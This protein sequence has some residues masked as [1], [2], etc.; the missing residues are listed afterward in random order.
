[1]NRTPYVLLLSMAVFQMTGFAHET[2]E[3]PQRECVVLLHGLSRTA[4]SMK[5]LEWDLARH[6]YEVINVSY[7]SRRFTVEQ[8]ADEYLHPAIAGKTSDPAKKIHFVTHSMGG[9]I[10]RQYLSNHTIENLGCVVMLAPPNQGSE[11]VDQLKRV[12]IGRWILGPGGCQLD[13][14]PNG[15]PK[16]LG[17][18]GFDL[19][20]IAG[21][22]SFN[23]LFSR[24]LPGLDDGKVSVES[25]RV[26]GMKDFLVV[27]NSHTWMPWRSK[28]ISHVLD[29]LQFGGF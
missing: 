19:G 8:L 10:L 14:C 5:R 13:S 17:P 25:T 18:A 12:M 29:Y 16:H 11:I 24:I 4:H 3:N 1:M 6:R 21:D 26:A 22:C 15:L 2:K 27:H 23:P 28:T 7:P 20:V 9:I